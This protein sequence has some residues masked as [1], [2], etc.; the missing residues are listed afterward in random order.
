MTPDKKTAAAND[1][2]ASLNL[3]AAPQIPAVAE[4]AAAPE[5]PKTTKK[6]TAA[7]KGSKKAFSKKTVA[8]K[9]KGAA[10]IATEAGKA[11]ATP[12]EKKT[13]AAKVVKAA[14]EK[15]L[16]SPRENYLNNFLSKHKLTLPTPEVLFAKHIE[17]GAMM[18]PISNVAVMCHGDKWTNPKGGALIQ[19]MNE[20]AGYF[21]DDNFLNLS[22]E[23]DPKQV[24]KVMIDVL[25][26]GY[27]IHCPKVCDVTD[28]PEKIVFDKSVKQ[29]WDG[30]HRVAMLALAYGDK[31]E[32]PVDLWEFTYPEALNAC[33]VSN[34]TR[35]IRKLEAIHYQG[36]K[37]GLDAAAA[38]AKKDGKI[39]AI[40]KFVAAHSI[41]DNHPFPELTLL[42]GVS[43][44]E[45][46]KGTKG[47]TAVNYTN[48]I[49]EA[50]RTCGCVEFYRLTPDTKKA[51]NLIT[52]TIKR[53]WLTIDTRSGGTKAS[54][55][56]NAY[57]SI[58]L[59]RMI[60]RAIQYWDKNDV[61]SKDAYQDFAD[62][63]AL[64]VI[65]FMDHSA[66]QYAR[67][68][69]VKLEEKMQEYADREGIVLVR[70]VSSLFTDGT[71]P[72]ADQAPEVE[73]VPTDEVVEPVAE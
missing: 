19:A 35:D 34:D 43:V 6:K 2:T 49:K 48:A 73:A 5:A 62:N 41:P 25:T 4:A 3:E 38:Y 61:T 50:I 24:E 46:L 53:C 26:T 32:I 45:K 8:P 15:V 11:A 58:V 37:D 1:N 56:W 51:F 72:E 52:A 29:C 16:L 55:A 36:L 13:R 30:R 28:V 7:K 65:G 39:P 42:K 59:G 66:E 20:V 22:A 64:L 31:V 71:E 57:S 54:T 18:M 27:L 23:V 67:T 63:L 33:I 12:K 60:G 14:V 69:H 40:A 9:T 17:R 68:P 10:A 70:K 44:V 47:I 21:S